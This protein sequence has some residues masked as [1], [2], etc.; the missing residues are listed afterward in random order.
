MASTGRTISALL[1]N[2]LNGWPSKLPPPRLPKNTPRMPP[3][4]PS[5]VSIASM[6]GKRSSALANADFDPRN[7]R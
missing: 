4:T 3:M 2:H 6:N 7:S 1:E 5:G